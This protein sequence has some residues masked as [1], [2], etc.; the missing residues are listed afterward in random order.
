MVWCEAHDIDHVFGCGQNIRLNAP[1]AREVE[2][3]RWRCLVSGLKA[4]S[5]SAVSDP[6]VMVPRAPCGGQGRVAAGTARQERPLRGDEHLQEGRCTPGATL[7]EQDQG[8]AAVAVLGAHMENRI[9]RFKQLWHG[10]LRLRRR[11]RPTSCVGSVSK[12]QS[13][14]ACACRHSPLPTV[15]AR[16]QG[17][18]NGAPDPPLS[19]LDL[20]LAGCVRPHPRQP[21]C[22]GPGSHP[23]SSGSI[24]LQTDASVSHRRRDWCAWRTPR[25]A[26]EHQESGFDPVN[27]PGLAEKRPETRHNPAGSSLKLFLDRRSGPKSGYHSPW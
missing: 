23:G 6:L 27:L 18:K 25:R 24:L 3:S 10:L 5:G 14:P 20:P 1:I 8:S 11:H 26:P 9:M 16:R 4:L 21:A 22:R 19:G 13:V 17:Q 15:Q 2:R 12:A 7:R